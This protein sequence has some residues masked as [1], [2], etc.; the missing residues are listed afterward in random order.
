M[1]SL[2]SIGFTLDRKQEVENYP[3]YLFIARVSIQHKGLYKVMTQKGEFTAE[4]S[5]KLLYDNVS[6]NNLPVVGDWVLVN[7]E[8]SEKG[9]IIIHH[10]L[11]RKSCLERKEAGKRSRSQ[12]IAA[13]V[14]TVFIC[15][16]MNNDFN[17]RRL[18]RYI[19]IVWDGGA[20][21]V[22][23][24]TKVDLCHDRERLFHEVRQ[25]ACGV[26]IITTS[27]LDEEGYTDVYPYIHQGKTVAFIGSSGVGK[28]TLINALLHMKV[29][30]TKE[31]RNDDKGR[32]TT[33]HRQLFILP[34]GGIVIDT[35]GMRELQLSGGDI[36][37]T[38]SDI[39]ELSKECKFTDCRHEKE[40]GCKVKE[41][42]E[43]G[44]INEN[45]LNSYKKLLREIQYQN[46][47]SQDREKEKINQMF[48]SKKAM[49]QARDFVKNKNKVK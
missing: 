8:N 10:I 33:T 28:S 20:V 19:T 17:L 3:V 21:P 11:H 35:P 9:N 14:D 44:I 36:E 46:L 16:S 2:E 22:V 18:E 48:G 42:I 31:V 5:G 43:K 29:L 26:D 49:K 7:K 24:L 13:N 12:V 30:E 47:K 25:V 27:T 15:M 32:H 38:F 1:Y 40:P 37:H 34:Q 39:E 45:R 41:A 6:Q 4:I 23:V